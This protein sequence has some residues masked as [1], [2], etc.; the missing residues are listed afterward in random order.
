MTVT[1]GEFKDCFEDFIHHQN[2]ENK[3]IIDSIQVLD[4]NKLFQAPGIPDYVPCFKNSLSSSAEELAAKWIQ[5][6][7]SN[8]G[9]SPSK[10]DIEGW[11]SSQICVFLEALM[12]CGTD[13]GSTYVFDVSVLE[14]MDVVYGLSERRNAEIKFRWQNMC[15]KSNAKWIVP[16]VVD[17]ITSQGRMKF[18][19]PL[20]RA[21]RMSE[22]GGTLAQQLFDQKKDM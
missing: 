15:L 12:N 2:I 22:V 10:N 5:C 3:V 1:S 21:L 18:V 14:R 4:W 20:Y 16:Y 13:L 6:V 11:T 9:F 8:S 7:K 19:R 17:F